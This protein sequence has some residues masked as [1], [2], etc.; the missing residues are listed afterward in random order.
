M[1]KGDD[2]MCTNRLACRTILHKGAD[3]GVSVAKPLRDGIVRM[4]C[5]PDGGTQQHCQ[6]TARLEGAGRS[7]DLLLCPPPPPPPHSPPTIP[8]GTP[9]CWMP[10]GVG[11]QGNPRKEVCSDPRLQ[12]SK[13]GRKWTWKSK[14]NRRE[15]R[16]GGSVWGR[17]WG[18]KEVSECPRQKPSILRDQHS[19]GL[20]WESAQILW[21]TSRWPVRLED[22]AEETRTW[23]PDCG[24]GTGRVCGSSE[25][26][27]LSF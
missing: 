25:W 19:S 15:E 18:S 26:L 16:S 14:Q 17:T 12:G 1:H 2:A 11:G 5:G 4:S 7:P 23:G 6:T 3:E 8:T 9:I 27:C 22:Q 10:S 21:E 20:R 13:Q 24:K